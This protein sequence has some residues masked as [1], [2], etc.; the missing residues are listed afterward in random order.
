MLDRGWYGWAR[1][2]YAQRG[3]SNRDIIKAGLGGVY[4]TGMAYFPST[5]IIGIAGYEMTLKSMGYDV[6]VIEKD[7]KPFWSNTIH[8]IIALTEPT[9]ERI[10]DY[11]SWQDPNT[12]STQPWLVRAMKILS[13]FALESGDS[14]ASSL[15]KEYAQNVDNYD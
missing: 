4:F 13:F 9:R 11:G 1:G 15:A 14:F 12:L 8:S 7:L 10:Y 2:Y 5:D 6:N 3:I